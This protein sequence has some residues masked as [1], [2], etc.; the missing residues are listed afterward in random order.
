MKFNFD[1]FDQLI[2]NLIDTPEERDPET[3]EEAVLEEIHHLKEV[4]VITSDEEGDLLFF[5]W[6]RGYHA[7]IDDVE[8]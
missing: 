8:P 6:Y 5:D 7:I 3:V 4:G 2:L 1:D